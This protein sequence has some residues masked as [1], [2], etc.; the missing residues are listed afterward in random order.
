MRI[1]IVE[2]NPDQAR[3]MEIVLKKHNPPFEVTLAST[4]D[5]CF[6]VLAES[7]FDALILDYNLPRTDGLE[8][9]RQIRQKGHDVPIIVVTGQGDEKVAVQAMKDGAYDYIIKDKGYFQLLPRVTQQAVEKHR[10]ELDKR[11]LERQILESKKRLQSLFDSITDI[12]SV[13]DRGFNI[14]MANRRIAEL[15]GTTPEKLIGKKCY[16]T[17]FR[18]PQP[19]PDCPIAKTFETKQPGFSELLEAGEIYHIWSYPMFDLEGNLDYVIEY[20]KIVTEQKRLEKKLIQSEKL[21]TIGLLSS[22]IAHELRNPLN[23]IE[24]ARYYVAHTLGDQNPDLAHKLDIIKRNVHRASAIINN[25]LEF[26][27][28]SPYEREA[29]ETSQLLDQTL[30]LIEKDLTSRNIHL[31]RSYQATRRVFFGLDSLKQVLLNIIINAIQAMPDGGQLRVATSH[32]GESW[33][34]VAISDTG[35]GMSSESLA[36]LF[37][38]FFTTKGVGGGTGLGMFVSHSIVKREGGEILVESQEGVG[39]TFRVRL[40]CGERQSA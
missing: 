9:L 7:K 3:L 29:I 32:V 34:E 30:A 36:N 21:A 16:E 38:P 1:L 19:C 4:G 26:S 22:G 8:V 2:D 40:P 24:T 33:V 13:Q 5:E 10:L 20:A 37:T 35:H 39:T 31:E 23:I 15:C 14:V 17:Y 28:P 11:K 27:R 18:L 12:I 6:R 25:L